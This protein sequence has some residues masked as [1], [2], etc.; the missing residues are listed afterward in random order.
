MSV[1]NDVI[2]KS[3]TVDTTKTAKVQATKI[4]QKVSDPNSA[5]KYLGFSL[6]LTYHYVLW[7]M[8]ESF[9]DTN[10]LSSTITIAWLCNLVGTSIAMIIVAVALGR[11]KHLS[12]IQNLHYIVPI[13][14]IAITLFMQYNTSALGSTIILNG[15]S[16]LAGGI[17]GLMWVLWGECLI[18]A[19]AKFSVMHIGAMFGCT[20]FAGML[21]AVMLPNFVVPLFVNALLVLSAVLLL[22]QVR[23]LKEDF[24]TLLPKKTV[25]GARRTV[26]TVSAITFITS[27][28]CYFLI[29]IIPWELLPLQV[30]CFTL[31]IFA[32]AVL[33]LIISVLSFLGQGKASIF[34][35]FPYYLV[36]SIISF[37]MFLFSPLFNLP[38]FVLALCISSLLEVS[39]IMYFGIL[40]QRGFFAPATAFAFSVVSV[41]MGIFVGNCLAVYYEFH[42][43]VA[44]VFTPITAFVFI[45]LLAVVLVP[46]A[47]HETDVLKL[48]SAPVSPSETDT[49]CNQISTQFKLSERETE[50]LKLIARGNTANGIAKKLIIS[51]HT[52]NT[53]I[54][55]IYEKVGIHKRNELLEYINMRKSD[56]E[57]A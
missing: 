6:L 42:P 45:I 47:K 7:F 12:D 32:A 17:E 29:A 2:T 20:L 38:S 25:K 44:E 43:S 48:T 3:E 14:L 53:H 39:L 23:T 40:M 4:T 28:A 56:H 34:K 15:C 36:L 35:I 21:F 27:M 22:I 55:N 51:P 46:I 41:R 50:I 54:R 11:N 9:Y 19:R 52:V 13:A 26:I 31:G 24:L 57:E 10:L 33:I 37:C 1:D 16:F 30:G 49:I 8:P 18:R 5:I